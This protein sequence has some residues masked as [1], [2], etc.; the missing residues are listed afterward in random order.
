MAGIARG[1]HAP[2]VETTRR[3]WRR[4]FGMLF[5]ILA[6]ILMLWGFTILR[7]SL[8]GWTYLAYWLACFVCAFAAFVT[9]LVDWLAL[10][11]EAREERRRLLH[12]TLDAVAKRQRERQPGKTPHAG[13]D[14][15][16][17]P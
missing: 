14:Q 11:R 4:W 15:S 7:D 1:W 12:G 17:N 10:R 8:R 6:A 5:L 2:G 13:A 9:A 16:P 3:A